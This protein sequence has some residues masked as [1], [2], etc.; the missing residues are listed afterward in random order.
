MLILFLERAER[1][2]VLLNRAQLNRP[3]LQSHP[4]LSRAETPTAEVDVFPENVP[5]EA[6]YQVSRWRF[7]K[8]A[9]KI[10]GHS[11]PLP[12]RSARMLDSP[13]PMAWATRAQTAHSSQS[14]PRRIAVDIARRSASSTISL[15]AF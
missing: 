3:N 14:M 4:Q 11:P 13:T 9:R 1:G 7:V 8:S 6:Y 12:P 2:E 5:M 10:C 15:A